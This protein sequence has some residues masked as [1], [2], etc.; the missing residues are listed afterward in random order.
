MPT[1]DLVPEMC[2]EM[3]EYC[4][5][6]DSI[7]ERQARDHMEQSTCQCSKAPACVRWNL[8]RRNAT[9]FS[10]GASP[11]AGAAQT[12]FG[13]QNFGGL[14]ADFCC[15]GSLKMPF[16]CNTLRASGQKILIHKL[17]L[18]LNHHPLVPSY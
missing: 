4:A 1:G 13:A 3:S 8:S 2:L 9:G 10:D 15:T 7:P 18:F 6:S 17:S 16:E 11:L 14:G 5:P 12:A